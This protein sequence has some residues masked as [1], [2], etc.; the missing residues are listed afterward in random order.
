M[1]SS[2]SAYGCHGLRMTGPSPLFL[3]MGTLSW[4]HIDSTLRWGRVA[5]RSWMF[6][7]QRYFN[8]QIKPLIWVEAT[9]ERHSHSRVEYLIKV[10][11]PHNESE[12]FCPFKRDF[13][14]SWER[15]SLVQERIFHRCLKADFCFSCENRFVFS[16]LLRV[17]CLCCQQWNYL[18]CVWTYW[19]DM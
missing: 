8:W 2:I 18:S 12:Y 16:L 3:L 10:C 13:S 15:F 5:R 14:F 4:C 11:Q 1:S 17:S 9:I 6:T 7:Y 19:E